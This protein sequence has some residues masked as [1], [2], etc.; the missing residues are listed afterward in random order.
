M[1]ETGTLAAAAALAASGTGR[2]TVRKPSESRTIRAGGIPAAD[3]VGKLDYFDEPHL[4]RA[5]RR[6]VGRTA[7]Q[8]RE[9]TGGA[10]ALDV[11]QR[12]AR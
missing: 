12:T 1:V 6:Y 9:G 5:L 7:G 10:L 3:V 2:P 4:A 8:L 11:D